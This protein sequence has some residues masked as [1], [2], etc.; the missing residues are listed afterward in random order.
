[1]YFNVAMNDYSF[2]IFQ[3]STLNLQK[4]KKKAFLKEIIWLNLIQVT[5]SNKSNLQKIFIYLSKPSGLPH[6][7]YNKIC[8]KDMHKILKGIGKI[9][10]VS[11]QIF[12]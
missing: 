4:K 9:L 11:Y 5:G 8:L 7:R 6:R 1:M 12:C 3:R 2:F 10:F